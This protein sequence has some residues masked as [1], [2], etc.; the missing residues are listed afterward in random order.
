MNAKSQH[1]EATWLFLQW[2]TSKPTCIL[3]GRGRSAPPARASTW[4]DAGFRQVFGDQAA[5]AAL[6]N[7]KNADANVMTRAWF[8][9][10]GNQILD[11]LAVSINQ[12]IVGQAD[13]K[14]AL[15]E[16]AQKANDLINS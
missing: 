7:L 9:P 6:A 4:S 10:K 8:H 11:A 14:T 16:G 13:A 15:T 1:K 3:L 2:V 12:V 5:E